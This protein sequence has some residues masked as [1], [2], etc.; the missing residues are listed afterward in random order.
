MSGFPDKA[1]QRPPSPPFSRMSTKLVFSTCSPRPWTGRY[2]RIPGDRS[3]FHIQTVG[4]QWSPVIL[5]HRD[6][7]LGT[8]E[9]VDSPAVRRLTDAITSAKRQLGGS[10]GGS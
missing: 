10:G 8:C 4:R 3:V 6:E 5:W 2:S 7:G 9:A 1:P